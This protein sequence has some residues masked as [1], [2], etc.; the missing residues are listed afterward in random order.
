MSQR[1][2]GLSEMIICLA[3][4]EENSTNGWQSLENECLRKYKSLFLEYCYS[5][6]KIKSLKQVI[7]TAE[8]D[9]AKNQALGHDSS[10]TFKEICKFN[11]SQA[12]NELENEIKNY[13]K[14]EKKLEAMQMSK[15]IQN[16]IRTRWKW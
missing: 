9:L 12:Q 16:A 13:D 7:N 11:I 2:L 15:P 4:G 10:H 14:L 6:T 8:S 5:N 3:D 1:E